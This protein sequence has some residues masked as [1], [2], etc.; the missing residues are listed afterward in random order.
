[1][2]DGCTPAYVASFDGRTETLALLLANKAD[3]NAASKVQQ[4]KIF[5][6]L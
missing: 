2:Q 1:M 6:Y 5:K 4:F 3:I